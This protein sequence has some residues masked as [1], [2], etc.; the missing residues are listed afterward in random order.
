MRG[1]RADRICKVFSFKFGGEQIRYVTSG[2]K[3]NPARSCCTDFRDSRLEPP[4]PARCPGR[5]RARPQEGDRRQ[6]FLLMNIEAVLTRGAMAISRK[7]RIGLIAF[8]L[9]ASSPIG[10][11][12]LKLKF[13]SMKLPPDTSI[14]VE[15]S[16]ATISGGGIE[17]TWNCLCDKGEGTCSI[18]S[19][20]GR[21]GC[22]KD[23][24][25]T[26][27]SDCYLSMGQVA[28]TTAPGQK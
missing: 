7:A 20:E 24:G 1:P 19:G 26:C 5:P 27:K 9:L 8:A 11:L 12:D 28:I 21:I 3:P 16:T 22:A 23:P 6:K 2:I 18:A 17:T 4:R 10:A 15:G 14:R 13:K 25:D